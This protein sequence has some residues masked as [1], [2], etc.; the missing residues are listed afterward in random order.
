MTGP[1]EVAVSVC[2]LSKSYSKEEKP[3]VNN[4]S[5]E[6]TK[7]E[8]FGL[9]GPD[10]AGKTSIFRM[11]TTLI[12]PDSG[13]ASINGMD[14]R[15]SYKDIRS[16][17]GYMPGR[18]SLYQ[19]L[20]VKENLNFFATLFNTTVEAG[21]DLIRDIYVQIA[22]FADRRAGKLSG[23]M[24][25]KLALCCALVHNP[26]ILFLDEP[27]TGV[28]PV[29]RKEFWEML[30]DLKE[31]GITIVVSTPYMDEARLC[32][33]IALIQEGE[34]L[35]IDTPELMI[36]NYPD[37]LYAVKAEGMFHLLNA[38]RKYPEV[39]SAYAFGEYGHVTFS[40]GFNETDLRDYLRGQG[41]AEVVL[42]PVSP[43]IED[44]FIKL[45]NKS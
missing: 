34:I 16:H 29:S 14:V 26:P 35:S 23:G 4:V 28:D 10:G 11:L 39:L 44:C 19:D 42:R 36:S 21:Y 45:L 31:Q 7:G 33:R 6:V 1:V 32:D 18:F 12:L 13:N 22:P 5:F 25:Q 8:M 2:Q 30:K 37:Q 3:A 20:T 15:E 41:F 40:Q 43:N 38:L 9:I 24:K 27:T 17:V